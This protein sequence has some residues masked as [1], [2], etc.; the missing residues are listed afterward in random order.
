MLLQ[1]AFPQDRGA[2]AAHAGVHEV[3]I[4]AGSA[5]HACTRSCARAP[6]SGAASESGT[7]LSLGTTVVLHALAM[8]RGV[9]KND[10]AHA[11]ARVAPTH[12]A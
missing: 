10:G 4:V 7:T 11:H 5:V 2:R 12:A 8:L 3:A 9:P 1:G 6:M